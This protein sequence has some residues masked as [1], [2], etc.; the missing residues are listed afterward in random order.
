MRDRVGLSLLFVALATA[1]GCPNEIDAS[2]LA[3][4]AAAKSVDEQDPR[5][6]RDGEDLY[7]AASIERAKETEKPETPTGLGSGKPDESNGECRLFAPKLAAPE[8]CKSEYG[9]DIDAVQKACGLDLFLGESFQYSCGYYFN[10]EG[11]SP[12]WMRMGL[13]PEKDPKVSASAHDKKLRDITKN[14]QYSSSPVPGVEGALWSGHDGNRWAFLPGWE[15][16]RQ[17]SWRDETCD[18]AGMIKVIE[19]LVAAKQPPKGARRQGLLP[20]A[21]T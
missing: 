8:C 11:K 14:P 21:R 16:V 15:H 20:K 10:E 5:V 1:S 9:F 4:K 2:S 6:V 18:E 12:Q 3:P 17:L 13:L 19:Q 7:P